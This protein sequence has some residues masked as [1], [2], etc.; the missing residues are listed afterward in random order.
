MYNFKIFKSFIFH[1]IFKHYKDV[2]FRTKMQCCHYGLK[3]YD[4]NL[5]IEFG[6]DIIIDLP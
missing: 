1:W 2:I 4:W 3:I 6:N 5:K